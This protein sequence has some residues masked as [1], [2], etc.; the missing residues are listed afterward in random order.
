MGA[1]LTSATKS[2]K[3]TTL[4]AYCG[5]DTRHLDYVCDLNAYK[6]GRYMGGNKLPIHA[7]SMLAENPPDYVLILAWNFAT[8]I[9]SQNEEFARGG[10][11][12][13]VPVP[14]PHIVEQST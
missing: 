4:L 12:F 5:I 2:A 13:I 14:R 9:M 6:Q 1:A 10:G 3:A 7:P 11:R 8:E